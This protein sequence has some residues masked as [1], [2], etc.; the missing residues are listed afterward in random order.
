[1]EIIVAVVVLAVVFAVSWKLDD[2]FGK[3]WYGGEDG[4]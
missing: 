4:M 1:M 2:D 3:G